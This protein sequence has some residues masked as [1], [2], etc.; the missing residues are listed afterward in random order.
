MQSALVAVLLSMLTAVVW[1]AE[2]EELIT[3]SIDAHGAALRELSRLDMQWSVDEALIYES[4]RP[5]TPWDRTTVWQG[6]AVDLGQELYVGEE[7]RTGGGYHSHRSTIANGDVS[8]QI[9]HLRR[10]TLKS[11]QL[12]S[13]SIRPALLLSPALLLR[14]MSAQDS[15]F[16]RG[17][18]H[19]RGETCFP[20]VVVSAGSEHT[21]SVV[22]DPETFRVSG[23]RHGFTDYDG[24]YTPQELEFHDYRWQSGV[25]QP[26][27]YTD[28][29]WGFTGRRGRLA[30]FQTGVDIEAMAR[31]PANLVELQAEPA[32]LRDFRVEELATGIYLAGDGVFYQ[33]FV[34]FEEFIVALDATSGDVARRIR[35]IEEV[36]P[37][38][39]FRYVL[40]SHH[41]NDHLHGLD[42][43]HALG[44]TFLASPAH[45]DVIRAR[46]PEAD[47]Q[48]VDDDFALNEHGLRLEI[49]DIGPLPH[50][51][52]MLAGW[53]PAA[54]ILF[55]A[56]LFVLGGWR[57]PPPVASDNAVALW[58]YIEK[59]EWPVK[60]IV[61]PHSPRVATLE[62]LRKAVARRGERAA[63]ATPTAVWGKP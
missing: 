22:F 20:T 55:E 19:C 21:L 4:Q 47:L 9:N 33:L 1:G 48:L 17:D 63:S 40:V 52:H 61:D 62:D 14:W 27:A 5:G 56:D 30:A 18:D 37:N 51:E 16:Q 23:I 34:E 2:A 26:T 8:R 43:Y 15:G 3:R 53:L 57:E 50:S 28:V 29:Y 41:H 13:S 32:G 36:I 46:I 58:Q 42:E 59:R 24:S 44:A 25:L 39:P 10:T 6:H 49:I 38:K 31:P 12:F 60:L 54:G 11:E 45:A 35:A 7:I